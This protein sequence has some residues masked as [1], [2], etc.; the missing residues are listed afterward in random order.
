MGRVNMFLSMP[1]FVD[2]FQVLTHDKPEFD[3][4]YMLMAVIPSIISSAVRIF[5]EAG[6][7]VVSTRRIFFIVTC[8]LFLSCVVYAMTF[9]INFNGWM[10]FVA[11]LLGLVSVDI[12]KFMIE[13]APSILGDI[14]NTFMEGLRVFVNRKAN[15]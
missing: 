6:K 14:R 15:K 9:V 1:F 5:Y 13:Q 10:V 2:V 12:V 4:V 8:S 7:A 3:M 11:L